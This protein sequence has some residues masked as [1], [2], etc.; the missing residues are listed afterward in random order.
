MVLRNQFSLCTVDDHS[1]GGE[2][3][4]CLNTM[5]DRHRY[6]V[7]D[8]QVAMCEYHMCV[9][10]LDRKDNAHNQLVCSGGI[11]RFGDDLYYFNPLT[12]FGINFDKMLPLSRSSVDYF[13]T[14]VQYFFQS[15]VRSTFQHDIMEVNC[16]NN[17]RTCIKFSNSSVCFGNVEDTAIIHST[18]SLI[19]GIVVSFFVGALCYIFIRDRVPDDKS[20]Y[21]VFAFYLIPLVG[22]GMFF[23]GWFLTIPIP[24]IMGNAIVL[25]IIQSL[26]YPL[27]DFKNKVEDIKNKY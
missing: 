24:Y 20:L 12:P 3:L 10:V 14:N 5:G 15:D 11:M 6:F 17:M 13:A 9:I 8:S 22:I 4:S 23:N 25:F 16:T 2:V 1:S 19:Y 27:R 21:Y 7:Y 26:Y 18:E